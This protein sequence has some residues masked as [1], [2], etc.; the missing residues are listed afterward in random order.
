MELRLLMTPQ[1]SGLPRL[2]FGG[3]SGE[4]L[5]PNVRFRGEADIP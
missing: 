2:S 5:T 1:C 3:S 4:Y